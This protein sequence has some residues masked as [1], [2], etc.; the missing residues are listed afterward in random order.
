MTHRRTLSLAAL[1]LLV[2]AG[3]SGPR[4]MPTPLPFRAGEPFDATT[5]LVPTADRMGEN[6]E[7]YPATADVL[8]ATDRVPKRKGDATTGY[9]AKRGITTRLGIATV[10]FGPPGSTVSEVTEQLAR[11]KR[12]S[13]TVTELREIGEYWRTIPLSDPRFERYESTP[14]PDDPVRA[15]ERTFIEALNARLTNARRVIIYVPGYNTKFESPV[16]YAAEFAFFLHGDAVPVAFSWPARSTP[17]GY[18]KQVTTANVSVR[19]LRELIQLIATESA[20]ERIDILSYS[21]G[22]PIVSDALHELLLMHHDRTDEEIRSTLKIGNV[23]YAGADEDIDRFRNLYLDGFGRVAERITLYSSGSD[24]GLVMSEVI[25]RGSKRLG[26]FAGELS[27]TERILLADAGSRTSVVDVSYAQRRAGGG[28]LYSHG[29]WFGNAW[30]S[31]DVIAQLRFDLPPGERGLVRSEDGDGNI[32]PVWEFPRNYPEQ[33]RAVY[34]AG[35]D[36]R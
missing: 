19:A 28:D 30:V 8:Y 26:R 17:L 32:D 1:L 11:N 23:I 35:A 22:A 31:S 2:V 27:E 20:A 16:R 29:Y 9:T 14:A 24:I 5:V 25:A 12:P 10:R 15:A 6:L 33:I 3:C 13:I 36:A 34:S 21:A 18:S 4:V 7:T